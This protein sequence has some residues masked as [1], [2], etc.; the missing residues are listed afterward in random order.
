MIKD[1]QV[2]IAP[3]DYE[4]EI[5]ERVRRMEIDRE[6]RRRFN[7]G[8]FVPPP[9][10][11]SGSVADFMDCW[12]T[13]GRY[14]IDGICGTK[15]NVVITAQWKTGKTTF[16]TN[17]FRCLADGVPVLGSI[18][19][20]QQVVGMWSCEMDADDLFDEY[21]MPQEPQETDNFHIA[22]LR[23]YQVNILTDDGKAWAVNWLRSRKVKVWGIDSNARLARMSGVSENDNDDMTA[24]FLAID[25]IKVEAGVDVCFILAHTGRMEHEEG[26]E[27]ARGATVIDDWPDARW[28][29][30]KKG[31][32]RFLTV[33]GRRV[34][35]GETAL[36][37]DAD[38]NRLTLGEGNRNEYALRGGAQDVADIV[39]TRD[40]QCNKRDIRELVKAKFS[41]GTDK[42]TSWIDEAEHLGFVRTTDGPN[43]QKFYWVVSGG[44][45]VPGGPAVVPDRSTM[46]VT[47]GGPGVNGDHHRNTRGQYPL[48]NSDVSGPESRMVD[49]THVDRRRRRKSAG[50]R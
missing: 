16:L 10:D 38:T 19:V 48:K 34:G 8:N 44:P 41:V 14:L 6:A 24:L 45:V 9:D 21:L 37:F 26:K 17:I 30:V 42:A 3:L 1:D 43:R 20:K 49:F 36:M 22:N 4:N 13:K 46:S 31:N 25:E 15:H 29:L 18:P 39:V 33:D 11:A 35:L 47:S 7:A 50:R 23:G 2:G 40:G 27:R 12:P 32:V 5:A 28:V